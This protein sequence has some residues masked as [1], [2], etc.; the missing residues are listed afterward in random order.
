MWEAVILLIA[1]FILSAIFTPKVAVPPPAAVEDFEFPT[2]DEGTP[3]AVYFGECW[4][5]GWMVL[6]HGDYRNTPIE[7]GGGGKK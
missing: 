4:S 3:Q 2:A 6:A 7:G 5:T 1:S